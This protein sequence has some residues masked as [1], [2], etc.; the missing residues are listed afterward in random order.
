MKSDLNLNQHASHWAGNNEF[1]A[2][3]NVS[4]EFVIATNDS[5]ACLQ[6]IDQKCRQYGAKAR[7][8]AQTD[9]S[10][11]VRVDATT[12]YAI[13][14][15]QQ[16]ALRF[17]EVETFIGHTMRTSAAD[18]LRTPHQHEQVVEILHDEPGKHPLHVAD[19]E[20]DHLSA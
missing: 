12:Y 1:S 16:A 20:V 15:A 6:A 18:T 17:G 8:I 19:G 7:A 11:D 3:K 4:A 13:V 5:Q 9:D 2:R 10:L 14:E